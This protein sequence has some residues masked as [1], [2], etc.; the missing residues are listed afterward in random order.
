MIGRLAVLLLA[1]LVPVSAQADWHE[2]SSAHFVVYANDR[3]E[4]IVK[5]TQELEK[6][7]KVMRYL[8]TKNPNPVVG[9]ANRVTVFVMPRSRTIEKL[10]GS[11]WVAGFY[12]PRAG[13]NVA[14][15]PRDVGQ[16]D[17]FDLSGATVLRHEYAHHFMYSTFP[18]VFPY[19]FSEGFAEYFATMKFD[20]DGT[21]MVGIAP[22][23]R[24][25]GLSSGNPLPVERMIT[26]TDTRLNSDQR[27]AL[28][29]RGW[30]LTHYLMSDPARQKQ[31]AQYIGALN[32]GTSLEK[33]A[34][35][36]GDLKELGNA[37]ERHLGRSRLPIW[38]IAPAAINPGPVK[39]RPLTKGEAAMMD[40]RV[41]SEAGVTPDE[42][43][44]VVIEA[45]RDAAPY[46][47]DPGVQEA[48]AEAEFDAGNH[49]EA[50]AAVDRALAADPRRNKALL[51]RA[52]IEFALAS[53]GDARAKPWPA[54][55]QAIIAANR[56]DPEDPQ[57]LMLYYR[58]FREAGEAPTAAAKAGFAK[59]YDTA[60]A[61]LG[62]RME[63]AFMFLQDGNRV[64]AREAL[65]TIAFHPHGRRNADHAR[66]L[67]EAIDRGDPVARIMAIKPPGAE[68]DAPAEGETSDPPA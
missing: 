46:P 56:A 33:A 38:R 12:I 39:L 47:N 54:V 50:A 65:R 55:R 17:P 63:A 32:Q 58:S 64:E 13:R 62:L 66:L 10:A 1:L 23:H 7:D 37:L 60:P 22:G 26:L 31:L 6:F 59:A 4:A 48:L 27:E 36:F 14:F 19:W 43:K 25:W 67:V 15:V 16:N 28:Y 40:V 18:A 5:F 24:S 30:L 42:A 49:A 53:K 34:E 61:D 35:S 45:R 51:Y 44:K 41:Q 3:P 9:P 29:G 8:Y 21:A 52:M 68:A 11:N 2:A 20:K 57:P